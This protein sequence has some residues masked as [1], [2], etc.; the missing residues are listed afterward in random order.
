LILLFFLW[1]CKPLQLLQLSLTP[2]L[3]SLCSIW[4]LAASIRV[5]IGQALAE[6]FRRQSCQAP[7]S[8]HFL[9]SAKSVRVWCLQMEWVPRW[10]VAV[11]PFLQSLLQFA[12]PWGRNNSVVIFLRWVN[13]PIP[14]LGGGRRLA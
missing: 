3:K 8:K 2:P 5:C 13:G 14:Q 7:V 11:W 10:V 12:F 4:G 9:A 6:P 1:G